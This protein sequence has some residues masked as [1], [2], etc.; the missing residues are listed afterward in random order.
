MFYAHF[1]PKEKDRLWHTNT[2]FLPYFPPFLV[3]HTGLTISSLAL[4]LQVSLSLSHTL[5]LPLS[6]TLSSVH[7]LFPSWSPYTHTHSIKR[8]HTHTFWVSRKA[9][10]CS[11]PSSLIF[12]CHLKDDNMPSFLPQS[13]FVF[14]LNVRSLS[15]W[16]PMGRG[17]MLK[18]ESTGIIAIP[19]SIQFFLLYNQFLLR[20]WCKDVTREDKKALNQPNQVH[21]NSLS[22]IAVLFIGPMLLLS[23]VFNCMCFLHIG[24]GLKCRYPASIF[25]NTI[26]DDT[27]GFRQQ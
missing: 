27:D 24:I 2:L 1:P 11:L 16:Q 19:L 18:L 21:D 15:L 7:I 3:L 4:T 8:T 5:S 6:F 26:H 17:L 13:N 12:Y 22:I 25:A 10:L 14:L 20:Y 9:L 23:L